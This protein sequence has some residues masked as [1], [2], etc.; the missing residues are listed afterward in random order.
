MKQIFKTSM[1]YT[2]NIKIVVYTHYY[3]P[4]HSVVVCCL[5][6]STIYLAA[7]PLIQFIILEHYLAKRSA[8]GTKKQIY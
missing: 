1:T 2:I 8:Q 5:F 3:Q 4:T 6:L 7:M